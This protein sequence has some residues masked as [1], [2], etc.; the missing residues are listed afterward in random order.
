MFLRF[1]VYRV[2]TKQGLKMDITLFFKKEMDITPSPTAG[3][4]PP[5]TGVGLVLVF[6]R[7]DGT[8]WQQ[9]HTT[10]GLAGPPAPS[11]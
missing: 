9:R 4:H 1:C 10:A 8:E 11:A 5:A 6:T 3:S 7:M 2:R